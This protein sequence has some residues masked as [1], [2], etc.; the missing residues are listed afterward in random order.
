MEMA[1]I[2]KLNSLPETFVTQPI[3]FRDTIHFEKSGNNFSHDHQLNQF[4]TSIGCSIVSENNMFRAK[5]L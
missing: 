1:I 3:Q 4:P 2:L 5:Q